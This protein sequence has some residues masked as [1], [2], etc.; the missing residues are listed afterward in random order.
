MKW[1][2]GRAVTYSGRGWAP[3]CCRWLPSRVGRCRAGHTSRSAPLLC[4]EYTGTY[5]T[6]VRHIWTCS[7]TSPCI[8]NKKWATPA[9]YR[10]WSNKS[11]INRMN[12]TGSCVHP[13]VQKL[14]H[15]HEWMDQIRVYICLGWTL[16][17]SS[18]KQ[19]F[20]LNS[21]TYGEFSVNNSLHPAEK[22]H[23]NKIWT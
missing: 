16:D 6:P 8:S 10:P 23:P 19:P 7:L 22:S 15:L 12:L 4:G 1:C 9:V 3:R 11:R 5:Q 20:T 2:N 14:K 13:W 21:H 17:T 18:V